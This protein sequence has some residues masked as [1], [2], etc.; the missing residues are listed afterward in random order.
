MTRTVSNASYHVIPTWYHGCLGY[1]L[2]QVPGI[3]Y[4]SAEGSYNIIGPITPHVVN[5]TAISDVVLYHFTIILQAK[6]QVV[7]GC[8]C[9]YSDLSGKQQ[10]RPV[11]MEGQNF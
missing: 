9:T 5:G 10:V 1:V 7:L 6:L 4:N 2:P 11:T 3:V 8:I